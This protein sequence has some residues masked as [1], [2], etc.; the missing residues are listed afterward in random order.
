MISNKLPGKNTD[1]DFIVPRIS[2]IT[3]T[4]A[5]PGGLGGGLRMEW[6]AVPVGPR[7]DA[8][9]YRASYRRL[10]PNPPHTPKRVAAAV[11]SPPATDPPAAIQS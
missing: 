8:S 1:L 9:L 11:L 7:S 5:D 6:A 10:V 2:E 3:Y 4:A